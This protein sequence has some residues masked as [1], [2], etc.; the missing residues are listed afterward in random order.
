MN[1]SSPRL[2]SCLL[3]GLC[4]CGG[5]TAPTPAPEAHIDPL[6]VITPGTRL[7]LDGRHSRVASDHLLSWQWQ[8]VSKPANSQTTLVD[9]QGVMPQLQPDRPGRYRIQ[10]TVSD[11]RHSATT[12]QTLQVQTAPVLPHVDAGSALRSRIGSTLHLQGQI[13]PSW[14]QYASARP[15]QVQWRVV[16]APAGS[17]PQLRDA[18]RLQPQLTPDLAGDYVLGL[19]A[20]AGNQ[21]SSEATVTVTADAHNSQPVARAGTDRQVAVGQMVTLD[22]RQSEDGD[23]DHLQW[24]WQLISRPAGSQTG[25]DSL[26][27]IT[28]RLAPDRSGDYVVALVVSDGQRDSLPDIRVIHASARRAA[29]QALLPA[30]QTLRTDQ[31]LVLGEGLRQRASAWHWQVLAA[32]A[33]APLTSLLSQPDVATPTFRTAVP[34]SYQ[35]ALT[36]RDGQQSDTRSMQ[37]EVRDLPAAVRGEPRLLVGARHYQLRDVDGQRLVHDTAS[38]CPV[39][40][41]LDQ[42]PDGHLYGIGEPDDGLQAIDPQNGHCVRLANVPLTGSPYYGLAIA[43]DGRFLASTGDALHWLDATGGEHGSLRYRGAVSDVDGIDFASDGTLYGY[44]WEGHA[45]VRIDPATGETTLLATLPLSRD[46]SVFDLDIDGQGVLRMLDINSNTLYRFSLA[47]KLL[48]NDTLPGVCANCGIK[49]LASL[50]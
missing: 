47:G 24:R 50:R 18:D 26:A 22:G 38:D 37:I 4:G 41:A 27:T 7:S 13:D 45:L 44:S 8:L 1:L 35:V 25:L 3:L 43:P 40:H 5:V 17:Q 11:G 42:A 12:Q 2:L 32:P 19:T 14:A 39:L 48:G 30:D 6:P 15:V 10:L 28:T 49:T 36:V 34:G 31:P 21:R 46:T 33:G 9:A 29:L 23:G 20:I 16:S